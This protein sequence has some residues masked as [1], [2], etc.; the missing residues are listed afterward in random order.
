MPA[1]AELELPYLPVEDGTFAA[2]PLRYIAEARTKHPWLAKSDIGYFV[3]EFS[4]IREFLGN[5]EKLR[6]AYDGIVGESWASAEHRGDA[7][8]KSS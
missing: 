1:L 8:P 3:H 7:S 6:P 4:A 2:D 5:D